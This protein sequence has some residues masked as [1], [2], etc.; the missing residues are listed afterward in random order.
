[1]ASNKFYKTTLTSKRRR[2]RRSGMPRMGLKKIREK[3]VVSNLP[4]S[5]TPKRISAQVLNSSRRFC[6]TFITFT[7]KN[8]RT[9]RS[10]HRKRSKTTFWLKMFSTK[11]IAN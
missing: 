7:R 6:S 10:N 9:K 2:L 4:T 1:M 3:K 11:T 5:T 8:T